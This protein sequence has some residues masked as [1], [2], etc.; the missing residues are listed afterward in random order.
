VV[1]TRALRELLVNVG[2]IVHLQL[3]ARAAAGRRAPRSARAR[4]SASRGGATR[5]QAN[6]GAAAR[7]GSRRAAVDTRP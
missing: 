3:R 2:A 5:L 1:G 6:A 4:C 7:S